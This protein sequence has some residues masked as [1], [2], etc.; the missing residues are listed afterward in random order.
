MF[1]SAIASE[2]S[3]IIR[4][5]AR[6]A[7]R[8][9]GTVGRSWR[10][11]T[12]MSSR[13]RAGLMGL[14]TMLMGAGA[15]FVGVGLA[16]R[17]S[18]RNLESYSEQG[19]RLRSI[20]RSGGESLD[21]Y[22]N[23]MAG[24]DRASREWGFGMSEA[25][26]AMGTLKETGVSAAEAMTIM[27]DAAEFARVSETDLAVSTQFLVDA[28]NQFN[29]PIDQMRTLAATINVGSRITA[30]SV[31]QMRQSFRYA[32]VEMS[33]MGF[34][35]DEVTA[36][37]G[38]LASVGLKGMTAGTRLRQMMMKL[39]VMTDS[40]RRMAQGY[41]IT[42]EE[43]NSIMFTETGQVRR[44]ADVFR[45]LHDVYQRL[46]TEEARVRLAT[47]MFGARAAAPGFLFSSA[48]AGRFFTTLGH[49]SDEQRILQEH[50]EAG[51]ER[52]RGFAAQMRLARR[53][54]EELG[55][56]FGQMLF[57]TA[58]GE[59]TFGQTLTDWVTAI[60]LSDE[61]A[62]NTEEAR[63]AWNAL[64][65]E[66]RARGAE[67]RESLQGWAS[68]FRTIGRMLLWVTKFVGDHPVFA[69]VTLGG[70]GLLSITSPLISSLISIGTNAV[71]SFAA[72]ST[73][74]T[75]AAGAISGVMARMMLLRTVGIAGLTVAIAALADLTWRYGQD[76]MAQIMGEQDAMRELT[77]LT[78]ERIE[79]AGMTWFT[80]IPVLGG[81]YT[82]IMNIVNALREWYS[83]NDTLEEQRRTMRERE[84]GDTAAYVRSRMDAA[85]A[86]G[87]TNETEARR[88]TAG[89]I[90]SEMMMSMAAS[91]RQS[92]G[93]W[94]TAGAQFQQIMR[95]QGATPEQIAALNQQFRNLSRT[96][97]NEDVQAEAERLDRAGQS[98]EEMAGALT[99][100]AQYINAMGIS[101]PP[102]AGIR[103]AYP[104]GLTPSDT[105]VRIANPND[106]L[107]PVRAGALNYALSPTQV[108]TDRAMVAGDTAAP[109]NEPVL[110]AEVLQNQPVT[111][112]GR[113]IGRIAARYQLSMDQRRG[114]TIE[115]GARSQAA[116]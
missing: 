70:L 87:I 113:E 107:A 6:Q 45:H 110:R 102:S 90:S 34:R 17:A 100:L 22:A 98:A 31:D 68:L 74:S 46:P 18:V 8:T 108:A 72:I 10:S 93:D 61:T 75:T 21:Q 97:S 40:T 58:E 63:S 111:I 49:L 33:G 13:L 29:V 103:V 28:H 73:G 105:S 59:M 101:G 57:G 32:A 114:I 44:L 12:N 89:R 15:G 91:L 67:W 81:I 79:A 37:L 1:G 112:D 92:A 14:N 39:S 76:W 16:I 78:D 3:V 26:E 116:R 104:G 25:V 47:Q 11:L 84:F 23:L 42:S 62:R 30:T 71:T 109:R 60:R 36:G 9:F 7:T 35:A 27:R 5:D 48:E 64:T 19:A 43:L 50:T 94:Q 80:Y 56:T 4:A 69:S 66:M 53:A 38:A 106:R 65:P 96:M 99:R 41:G 77:R 95:A 54:G 86:R 85:R 88:Y 24:A 115:P 52:M 2:I 83:A 51:Q 55:I 82:G 20:I